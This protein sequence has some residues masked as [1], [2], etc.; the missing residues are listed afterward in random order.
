M[1]VPRIEPK[2]AHAHVTQG[3]A[4]IV[5]AYDD[6]RCEEVAVQNMTTRSEFEEKADDL[7]RDREIIFYCN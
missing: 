4:L 7:D 5:C 2:D 3:N 1:S 6:D